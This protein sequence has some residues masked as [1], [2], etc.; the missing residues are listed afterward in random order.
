MRPINATLINLYH[1]CHRQLWL[2]AHELRME[3]E[4]DA[5]YAGYSDR[6]D[7]PI[8]KTFDPLIPEL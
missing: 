4:S 1:V 8:P 2:H 7:P 5:V 3:H 6:S